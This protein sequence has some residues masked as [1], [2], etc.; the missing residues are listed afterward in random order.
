[1]HLHLAHANGH[2]IR[3]ILSLSGR[4]FANNDVDRVLG[5]CGCVEKYHKLQKPVVSSRIPQHAGHTIGLDIFFLPGK[6]PQNATVFNDV[7]SPQ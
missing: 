3:R 2:T 5:N 4:P 7:M 6:G 1:M